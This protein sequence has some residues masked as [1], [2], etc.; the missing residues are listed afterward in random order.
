MS[1]EN[2]IKISGKIVDTDVKAFQDELE[3]LYKNDA[4]Q[5]ALDISGVEFM[6]SYGL[7]VIVYFHT[8]M[9]KAGRTLV[10]VNENKDEE[11]YMNKLFET[12]NLDQILNL[13]DK[14]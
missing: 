1:S 3:R 6:D 8:R 14:L 13:T 5:V 7:G 12:T 2:I 10:I 4:A 11:A 9:E